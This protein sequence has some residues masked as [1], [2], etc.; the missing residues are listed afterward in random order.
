MRE[1]AAKE[2]EAAIE[3][4]KLRIQKEKTNLASSAAST[5]T[6]R[7]PKV[8]KDS[9]DDVKVMVADMEQRV[10]VY[11]PSTFAAVTDTFLLV[12]LRQPPVSIN[13][14]TGTG[15]IDGANSLSGIPRLDPRRVACRTASQDRGSYEGAHD[16][17]NL[18]KR[19]KP[20]SDG[21]QDVARNTAVNGSGKRKVEF[22]DDV[23]EVGTGKKGE[24]GAAIGD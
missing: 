24:G 9:I 20:T 11:E 16:L 18:V 10:S 14:P 1:E 6:S 4:C 2:M 22:T 23:E 19:R 15:A 5:A 8:T 3:S 12:E 13:D 7:K 17:T 21:R